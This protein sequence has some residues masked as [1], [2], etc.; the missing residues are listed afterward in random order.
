MGDSRFRVRPHVIL[1]G[2]P[3]PAWSWIFLHDRQI[4]RSPSKVRMFA[5]AARSSLQGALF[6]CSARSRAARDSPKRL[7]LRRRSNWACTWRLRA[8]SA[9]NCSGTQRPGTRSFTQECL[10]SLTLGHQCS[11]GIKADP[12][13]RNHQGVF[14]VTFVLGGIGDNEHIGCRIAES[15]KSDI[16]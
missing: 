11:A 2:L 4:G 9:S 7:R 10:R 13:F 3:I 5:R 15:A 1:E 12:G 14:R 8:L 6:R 16:A